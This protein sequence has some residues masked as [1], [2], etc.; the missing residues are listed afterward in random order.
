MIEKYFDFRLYRLWKTRQHS[1]LLDYEDLWGTSLPH[2]PQPQGWFWATS[3]G[4][5]LW[6]WGGGRGPT[7]LTPSLNKPQ[8]KDPSSNRREGGQRGRRGEGEDRQEKG[9]RRR[10]REGW[11]ADCEGTKRVHLMVDWISSLFTSYA[12]HTG[13]RWK[14]EKTEEQWMSEDISQKGVRGGTEGQRNDLCSFDGNWEIWYS[15]FVSVMHILR[16]MTCRLSEL[17]LLWVLRFDRTS[18]L[19]SFMEKHK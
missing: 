2:L 12:R 8:C 10:R 13:Q 16:M 4:C 14:G 7:A 3:V 19:K 18:L 11:H 1:K 15:P 9:R 17:S 5:G 6:A